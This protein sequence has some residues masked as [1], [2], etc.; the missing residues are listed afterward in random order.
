MQTTRTSLLRPRM[1]FA[2]IC[3]VF[4][5]QL[6]VTPAQGAIEKQEQRGPV[7]AFISLE[8]ESPVIGDTLTLTI[9]VRAEQGVELLMP[10][11]GEAL[12]QFAKLDFVPKREILADGSIV[13]TQ[14]YRLESPLSGKHSIPPIL[15]EFVDNRPGQDPAPEDLDAYEL[16]LP[17]LDFEVASVTPQ[18]TTAELKPPLGELEIRRPISKSIWPWILLIALVLAAVPIAWYYLAKA[19]RKAIRRS[20]YDLAK[21]RL[22]ALLAKPRTPENLEPFYVELSGI[23]RRYLEDRFELRAPELTTEEFLTRV[24]GSPDLSEEHQVLLREFLRT[25][26]LVKFAGMKPNEQVIQ[27][28]VLAATRFLDETAQNSPMFEILDAEDVTLAED[29]ANTLS[30][31]VRHG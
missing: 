21:A 25:A 30:Q 12:D 20:A 13:E 24:T 4:L 9:T 2:L 5:C 15:I 26:D 22:D 18:S 19:R 28:S 16:M 1:I 7:R 31:E 3:A 6:L 17:R 10:E 11:F 29:N 23:V 27:N 14:T 8:P